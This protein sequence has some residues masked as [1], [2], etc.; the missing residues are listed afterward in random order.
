M[1]ELDDAVDRDGEDVRPAVGLALARD[2]L[3][4]PEGAA[5]RLHAPVPAKQGLE[6]GQRQAVHLHV[7]VQRRVTEQAVADA[8][9]GVV[10]PAA[11]GGDLLGD[12]ANQAAHAVSPGADGAR[13]RLAC[14]APRA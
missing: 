6:L 4:H 3:E 7:E 11:G 8:A 9:A 14:Q 10:G 5:H 13:P 1:L 2:E 12:L